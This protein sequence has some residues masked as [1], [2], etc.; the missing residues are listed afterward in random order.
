MPDVTGPELVSRLSEPRHPLPVLF[1]SAYAERQL[2]RRGVSEEAVSILC[3]P[4]T[5]DELTAMA[6]K[7]LSGAPPSG[8]GARRAG[9]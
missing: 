2:L 9:A 3:E 1:M 4:F 6:E 5:A 8:G 7:V